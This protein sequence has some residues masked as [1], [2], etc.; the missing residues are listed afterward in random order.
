MLIAIIIAIAVK[1]IIAEKVIIQEVVEK[2][3]A[4]AIV[5]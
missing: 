2:L 1:V 4:I 5:E 3:I